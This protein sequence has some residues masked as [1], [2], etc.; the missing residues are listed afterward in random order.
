MRTVVG[1][2]PRVL[3]G[4]ARPEEGEGGLPSPAGYGTSL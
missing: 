4:H 3:L 2:V 1:D